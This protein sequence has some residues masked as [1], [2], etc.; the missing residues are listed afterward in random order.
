MSQQPLRFNPFV[1]PET[2][3]KELTVKSILLGC[4]FGVI[5][6]ASTV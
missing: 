4:L 5:F 6:G 2:N 3:M 1:S